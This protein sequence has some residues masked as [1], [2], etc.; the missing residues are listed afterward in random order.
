MRRVPILLATLT[1]TSL[2]ACA[3]PTEPEGLTIRVQG[4]V[5]ASDDRSPIVNADIEA[6]RVF[7]ICIENCSPVARDI[8]DDSGD[9]SLSFVVAACRYGMP[10]NVWVTH[11]DFLP[12]N[13]GLLDDPHLTCTE[14]LQ[15]IDVQLVR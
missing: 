9:Y 14:E 11:P 6:W 4:T 13:I 12:E 2:N 7:P 8:T 15:T 5:T 3:G 10:A 1:L